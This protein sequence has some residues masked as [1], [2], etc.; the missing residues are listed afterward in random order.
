MQVRMKD[1]RE[2]DRNELRDL[3]GKNLL[4]LSQL[5][6]VDLRLYQKTVLPWVLEQVVNCKDAIAQAYLMDAIIQVFPDEFHLQSLD[7]LD[8]ALGQLQPGV[9]V[10]TV[11]THLMTRLARYVAD[12][13]EVLPAIE[14][15][16]VFQKLSEAVRKA[17]T[18]EATA[19][20]AELVALYHALVTFVLQV[21]TDVLPRLDAVLQLCTASL[22]PRR[23][24]I[25]G[26]AV[27]EL[28]ALLSTPLERFD[29]PTVLALE[30]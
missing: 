11:L 5:E 25:T 4:V 22:A 27:H 9:A 23:D 20:V 2:K 19:T 15:A 30:S 6:G 13:Q 16:K 21:D 1:R 3:V 8:A 14:E 28:L 29:L 7:K 12:D 18:L 10:G 24:A 26:K 17:S